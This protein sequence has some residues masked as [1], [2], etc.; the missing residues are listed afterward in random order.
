MFWLMYRRF[1]SG[2]LS[3]NKYLWCHLTLILLF[4]FLYRFMSWYGLLSGSD[5]L[6]MSSLGDTL[7]H[8]VMT[9]FTISALNNPRSGLLRFVCVLQVLIAFIFLNL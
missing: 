4:G 6:D 1:R 7:Y 9:Q 3:R 5:A 8:S 2:L